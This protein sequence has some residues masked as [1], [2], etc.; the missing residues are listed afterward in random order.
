LRRSYG[1]GWR[2]T[3]FQICE[4]RMYSPTDM[5]VVRSQ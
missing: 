1:A 4:L 2:N 3:L 5:G